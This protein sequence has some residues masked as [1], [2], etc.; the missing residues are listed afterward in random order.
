MQKKQIIMIIG[1]LLII[2]L[3]AFIVYNINKSKKI[4]LE[5]TNI[6]KEAY[7]NLTVDIKEYN[8]IRTEYNEMLSNFI[9]DNYEEEKPKYTTL[10][11]NY[12]ETIKKIDASVNKLDSKCNVLY[13]DATINKI[14]S[15]Y[16][17][18]YEKLINLYITDINKYN[19]NIA[20]YN[21]Y[22]NDSLSPF[23]KV[24]NDY[25]DYNNDGNYE[26]S[27]NNEED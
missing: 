3:G 27:D 17:Q 26:G 20:K 12:N 25:I 1:I 14:C 16:K 2:F 15:N 11:N 13:N 5:N 8:G 19:S 23:E 4:N 7:N 22:K 6:I 24:H 21:E 10:L 18:M 9:M